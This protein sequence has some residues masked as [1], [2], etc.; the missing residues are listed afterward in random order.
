M[1]PP[2]ARAARGTFRERRCA[3]AVWVARG[4]P[5][6]LIPAS[7]R[8]S[9]GEHP[10]QQYG[11]LTQV[12]QTASGCLYESA[13]IACPAVENDNGNA[14]GSTNAG[15]RATGSCAAGFAP[16]AA[17]PPERTC[18]SDG[19]WDSDITN[20][21]QRTHSH[22]KPARPS[23]TN[24]IRT[25]FHLACGVNAALYCT[26]G[27][28]DGNAIWDD[29]LAS[30]PPSFAT[31]TCAEGFYVRAGQPYRLCDITGTFSEVQNPCERTSGR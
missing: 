20:A 15:Q 28:A 10:V 24:G 21:C 30:N 5:P 11:R 2:R 9:D 7:V 6:S 25:G 27:T 18:K 17:G 8:S 14:F 3:S 22:A 1:T 16:R 13:V 12:P 26:T 19:N 31:G 29:T 4:R 23:Y